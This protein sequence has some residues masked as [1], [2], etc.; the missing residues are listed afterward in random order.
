MCLLSHSLSS[1]LLRTTTKQPPM[2]TCLRCFLIKVVFISLLYQNYTYKNRIINK[3]KIGV[4]LFLK[5]SSQDSNCYLCRRRQAF[6]QEDTQSKE[7]QWAPLITKQCGEE[8]TTSK[9]GQ[10]MKICQDNRTKRLT[11]DEMFS[12]IHRYPNALIRQGNNAHV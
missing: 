8:A 9:N 3:A 2:Q 12:H 10:E 4:C 1:S 11:M 7:I 5:W 6:K